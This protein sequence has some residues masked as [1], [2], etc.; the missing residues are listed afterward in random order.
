LPELDEDLKQFMSFWFSGLISGLESVDGPARET[1]LHECGRACAR[2]YTAAVFREAKEGS[3][4]MN[5]FL[6]ALAERFPDA[7][8]ELLN[9]E[10][11]RVR[12]GKCACDLVE[13][14]L[15]TSPLICDCSAQN[16]KE[17]FEQA[18][19]RPITVTLESSLLRGAAQC[20]L[21][22]SLEKAR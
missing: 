10:T 1:I 22:V 19:E 7:T 3:A 2:S 17:N 18:L 11:I 15:V 21:L 9:D 20:E 4:D 8:Y 13:T 6:A 14:G 16:L 12:Y 5:A